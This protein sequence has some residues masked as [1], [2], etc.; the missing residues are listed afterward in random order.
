MVIFTPRPLLDFAVDVFGVG[1]IARMEIYV[2][3]NS[4]RARY[5]KNL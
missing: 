3:R 2:D 4:S 5:K 1:F